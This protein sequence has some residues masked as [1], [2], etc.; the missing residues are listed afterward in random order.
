[1]DDLTSVNL[2]PRHRKWWVLGF[3]LCLLGGAGAWTH[4]AFARHDVVYRVVLHG[5]GRGCTQ[6]TVR[7]ED[8]QGDALGREER[9]VVMPWQRGPF[10]LA[11]KDEAR[12]SA[13]VIGA[14]CKGLLECFIRVDGE[15]VTREVGHKHV[16]CSR[17]VR[18]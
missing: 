5:D 18:P 2:A 9:A 10:A 1:M 16:V 11:R 17:R 6:H 7:Y 13:S 3:A 8:G 15:E 4:R 12:V 14:D